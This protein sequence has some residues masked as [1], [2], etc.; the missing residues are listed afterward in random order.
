M[1]LRRWRPII[2]KD[3]RL[4][5]IRENLRTLIKLAVRAEIKRLDY[6]EDLYRQKRVNQ[7]ITPSQQK[8]EFFIYN[9]KE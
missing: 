3:I 8:R 1:R 7:K 6:L 9:K 5:V 2:I 4:R